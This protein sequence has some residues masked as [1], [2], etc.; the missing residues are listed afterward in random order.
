M[1]KELSDHQKKSSLKRSLNR[2]SQNI[3]EV[4]THTSHAVRYWHMVAIAVLFAVLLWSSK[5]LKWAFI[6]MTAF[7]MFSHLVHCLSFFLFHS[8]LSSS[9]WGAQVSHWPGRAGQLRQGYHLFLHREAPFSVDE[10]TAGRVLQGEDSQHSVSEEVRANLP[11]NWQG[12][13]AVR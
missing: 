10:S 8:D 12:A 7:K 9:H 11:E 6:F 4:S 13:E 5:F 3:K 2:F 1:T